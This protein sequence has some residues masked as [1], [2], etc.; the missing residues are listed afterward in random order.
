MRSGLL[1]YGNQTTLILLII[2]MFSSLS[3]VYGGQNTMYAP[4]R[5]TELSSGFKIGGEIDPDTRI[6][7]L[8]AGSGVCVESLVVL[9]RTNDK[10]EVQHF[11][12]NVYSHP[13][14]WETNLCF[15]RYEAGCFTFFNMDK[16]EKLRVECP[17][18]RATPRE[19]ALAKARLGWRCISDF[20]VT[21]PR[22]KET[23]LLLLQKSADA[24][25]AEGMRCLGLTL[26]REDGG[27]R[28]E[29]KALEWLGK[30][31]EAGDSQANEIILKIKQ[32]YE[33]VDHD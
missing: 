8:Y 32:E 31:V 11:F 5:K 24:G 21:L 28:D 14:G 7:F 15:F 19:A 13:G 17:S 27:A 22:R 4:I 9:I 30:A 3:E 26:L 20:S 29:K 12:E 6:A 2:L 25:C 33:K 16:C 1:K 18:L 23:G 10:W